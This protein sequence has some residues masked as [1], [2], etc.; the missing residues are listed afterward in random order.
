[1]FSYENISAERSELFKSL[2]GDIFFDMKLW[3][4]WIKRLFWKKPFGDDDSFNLLCFFTG[5]GCPP[6][7]T[8]KWI[9][10]SQFW[11][12]QNIVKTKLEKRTMQMNSFFAHLPN[13][14]H[15]WFYFYMYHNLYIYT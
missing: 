5:N 13:R 3:P 11:H 8:A 2:S 6:I 7:V 1:M 9:L 15:E 10:T 4:V 14:E 12:S